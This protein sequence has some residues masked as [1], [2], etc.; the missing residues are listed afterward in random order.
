MASKWIGGIH[1]GQ[2]GKSWSPREKT[3]RY[4]PEDKSCNAKSP[5]S[6]MRL[7][8]KFSTEPTKDDWPSSVHRVRLLSVSTRARSFVTIIVNG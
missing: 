1:K 6:D 5:E 4:D 3:H 7:H 2:V 8:V